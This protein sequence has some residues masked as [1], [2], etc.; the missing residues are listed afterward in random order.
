MRLQS[1][2]GR[3]RRKKNRGEAPPRPPAE[4]FQTALAA[5]S[6]E[7]GN[8]GCAAGGDEIGGIGKCPAADNGEIRETPPAARR[9]AQSARIPTPPVKR[10][11]DFP[12]H[13]RRPCNAARGADRGTQKSGI[14]AVKA[15]PARSRR[16][17]RAKSKSTGSPL[18]GPGSFLQFFHLFH[19][20]KKTGLR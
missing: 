1:A 11:P 2:G 15:L 16:S 14:A 13:E 5:G 6:P 9:A 20:L 3:N 12:C 8:W 18:R 17:K 19:Q 10:H 4:V 7:R